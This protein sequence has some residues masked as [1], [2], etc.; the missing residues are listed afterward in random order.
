M[1]MR[2]E[3]W[4]RLPGGSS[5][6][7]RNVPGRGKRA[8]PPASG[9]SALDPASHGTA[10]AYKERDMEREGPTVDDGMSAK[11][12]LTDEEC[13]A[14]LTLAEAAG[15]IVHTVNNHLNSLLLQASCLQL[16]HAAIKDEIEPLRVEV[17][18]AA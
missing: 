15:H 2:R 17:K 7:G 10:I 12:L 8:S 14:V 6:T 9:F 1:R 16:K 11:A 3:T 4:T 5:G 13:V 18:R